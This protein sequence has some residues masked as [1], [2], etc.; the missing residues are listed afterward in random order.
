MAF[1]Q[2]LTKNKAWAQAFRKDQGEVAVRASQG[3]APAVLWFGCSDSRVSPELLGD[4]TLGEVFVHRNIANVINADD[5]NSMSVLEYAVKY[6]GV[7]HVVV[8]GHTAC[9]GILAALS[10]Q[11]F[12]P[13][14]D[15]WLGNIREIQQRHQ[16]QLNALDDAGKQKL[17]TRLNVQRSLLNIAQSTPVQQRW[18]NSQAAPLSLHGVIFN[19]DTL[20]L[21]SLDLDVTD[22]DQVAKVLTSDM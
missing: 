20:Q 1:K 14:L 9:G 12:G 17:L 4:T 15:P 8:C 2:L 18:Q 7:Q 6:L 19:L 22:N 16:T 5:K 21:E 13:S 11:S 3:Q 10:G